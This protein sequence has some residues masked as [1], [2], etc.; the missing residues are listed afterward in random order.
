MNKKLFTQIVK[1]SVVGSLAFIIDYGVLFI[2]SEFFSINY[3]ISCIIS[4]SASVIFNYIASTK[5]IFV[6]K[7]SDKQK[8]VEFIVFIILSCIGLLINSF[9]MWFF[10][11]KIKM[12]Y[13]ITKVVATLIVMIYNFISRKILLENRN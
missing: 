13:L 5:W 1:F 7:N 3:L 2:L 12:H 8:R 4:F 9:I 6:L 10:V 11:E